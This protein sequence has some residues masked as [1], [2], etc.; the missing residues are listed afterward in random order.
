MTTNTKKLGVE[1]NV[2]S[3]VCEGGKEYYQYLKD[4]KSENTFGNSEYE[5]SF[6]ML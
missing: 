4:M 1:N 3:L 5:T 6:M 2:S